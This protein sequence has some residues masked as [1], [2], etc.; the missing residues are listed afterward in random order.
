MEEQP[1][2]GVGVFVIKDGKV[3]LGQR[4]SAHGQNTWG[5]PG[6]HLEKNEEI[7]DCARRETLEETG[8]KVK[9]V[10]LGPFT[11]DVFKETE[12]HYVTLFVLADY[13]S[14]EVQV[15]EPDK[16]EEWKWFSWGRE[17]LPQPLFLPIQNLLKRGYSPFR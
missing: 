16:M 12:K 4:R 5:F 3:L 17:N 15:R 11:N 1:K 9:N 2:V 14:G 13:E 6:G 8:V 7:E 10:R